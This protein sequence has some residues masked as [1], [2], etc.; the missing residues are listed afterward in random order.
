MSSELRIGIGITFYILSVEFR[1]YL[2]R[3]L[4]Q[5]IVLGRVVRLIENSPSTPDI[6]YEC[7]L[8]IPIRSI[9]HPLENSFDGAI[10]SR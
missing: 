7:R 2:F 6:I 5:G 1:T 8:C 4:I 3:D 9:H 10:L